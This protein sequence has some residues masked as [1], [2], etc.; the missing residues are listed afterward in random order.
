VGVGG[1]GGAGSVGM[2]TTQHQHREEICHS[3]QD[4]ARQPK[5]GVYGDRNFTAA[6]GRERVSESAVPMP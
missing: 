4:K 5:D 1:V 3:L 6:K 2:G